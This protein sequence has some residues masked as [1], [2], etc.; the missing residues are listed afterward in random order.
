MKTTS[1]RKRLQQYIDEGD[2]KLIRLMYAVAHEYHAIPEG[3][4]SHEFTKEDIRKYEERRA[5]RLRGESKTY[6]WD[7]A[8]N[9]ILKGKSSS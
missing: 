2:E 4:I 6:S 8:K 7:I 9:M 1:I 5:K 3:D